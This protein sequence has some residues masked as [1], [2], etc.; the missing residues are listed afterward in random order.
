MNE[1]ISQSVRYLVNFISNGTLCKKQFYLNDVELMCTF[2]FLRWNIT[3][4]RKISPILLADNK[5]TFKQ[6]HSMKNKRTKWIQFRKNKIRKSG[7]NVDVLKITKYF[8]KDLKCVDLKK[9]K[10]KK[11]NSKKNW[12][13]W[14]YLF[15]IF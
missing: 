11:I 10:K 13:R 8:V 1:S 4:L 9:N 15:R 14:L 12:C 2:Y 5:Y 6:T 7:F 3:D